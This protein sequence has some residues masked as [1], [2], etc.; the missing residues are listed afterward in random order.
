[1]TL[2]ADF[3]GR[4]F[5]RI[6][7]AIALGALFTAHHLERQSQSWHSPTALHRFVDEPL[8]IH[9]PIYALTSNLS[10]QRPYDVVPQ[11][12][13]AAHGHQRGA[14]HGLDTG[15]T[16][17]QE[18]GVVQAGDVYTPSLAGEPW[19]RRWGTNMLKICR[20]H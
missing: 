14:R 20:V 15:G 18:P 16:S 11:C 1:L 4:T 10:T 7:Q 5:S 3:S 6:D 13:C 8:S 12:A 2:D 19:V 17:H 9:V